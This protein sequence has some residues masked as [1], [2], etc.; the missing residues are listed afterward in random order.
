MPTSEASGVHEYEPAEV[1]T[2]S[3]TSLVEKGFWIWTARV[4]D[5]GSVLTA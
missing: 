3:A 5:S 4:N 2:S 1:W